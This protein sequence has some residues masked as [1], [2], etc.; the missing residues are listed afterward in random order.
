MK[1]AYRNIAGIYDRLFENMNKGLRLAGIRMFR[2]SLVSPWQSRRK[3]K[4]RL[5]GV[6][7]IIVILATSALAGSWNWK[8]QAVA[9]LQAGSQVIETARGPIEYATYGEGQRS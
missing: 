8:R 3:N 6:L 4:N 5:V 7:V 1:D 2:P 9:R